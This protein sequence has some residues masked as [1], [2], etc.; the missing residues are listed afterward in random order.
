MFYSLNILKTL[1]LV[2]WPLIIGKQPCS[3][4]I[5]SAEK[6][7]DFNDLWLPRELGR[8]RLKDAA[9]VE[10]YE[11]TQPSPL[12]GINVTVYADKYNLYITTFNACKTRKHKLF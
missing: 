1:F 5:V 7:I 2:L 6:K 12:D 9:F 4:S 10:V 11:V 3:A 8:F